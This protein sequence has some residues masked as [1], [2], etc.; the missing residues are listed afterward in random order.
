MQEGMWRA[1]WASRKYFPGEAGAF[2]G[3]GW[4]SKEIRLMS[5][6]HAC[7]LHSVPDRSIHPLRVWGK[8]PIGSNTSL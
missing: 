3:H 7:P 4:I 1:Y 2:T 8:H 5:I 6:N